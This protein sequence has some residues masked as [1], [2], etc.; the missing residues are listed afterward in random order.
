MSSERDV[1]IAAVRPAMQLC[2]AVRAQR[3]SG[4]GPDKLDKKDQSPVTIADYGSQALVCRAIRLAFPGDAIVAEEDSADLR[5][6]EN[7]AQLA[8]VVEF[9][10]AVVPDATESS[11]CEWID[12]GRGEPRGRYWVLDPIDGTKGFLR[13]DQ[14][15][16]ALGLIEE[17]EVRRGFL[18]CPVLAH[19]GGVG[20]L[21]VAERNGGVEAQ[22]EGGRA[23]A[24]RVSDV[25]EPAKARMAESV[26]SAHTN[27]GLSADFR[28]ELGITVEPVRMDSQA[29]YAAVARGSAD[30]YLR[31]PNTKTPDYR[32]CIWDHAAGWLVVHEAGGRITD[33]RGRALD[34]KQGRRLENNSGVLATNGR[35]HD[36]AL[37][38]LERLLK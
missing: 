16:I 2:E 8:A 35:L 14:Y 37:S 28:R 11:I 34:W 27:H 33:V 3:V 7:A 6:P 25:S 20:Q 30:I 24:I 10:R 5:R 22:D 4:G 17:G 29:K 13:N 38:L 32:E 1:G 21:L 9:V 12:L 31:A 36:A 19:D 18:G 15:A 26:E 23:R